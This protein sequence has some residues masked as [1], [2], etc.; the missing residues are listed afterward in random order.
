M[1]YEVFMSK[2][3]TL[4]GCGPV[5]KNVIDVTIELANQYNVPIILVASRRQIDKDGGYVGFNTKTF[6]SYVKEKDKGHNIILERDHG[7]PWEG[8]GEFDLLHVDA[9]EKACESYEEDIK[10]GF[11]ILHID[12]S[13][14]NRS[15]DLIYKD[16]IYLYDQ[17]NILALY[18]N[19][20]ISF[21][22]G[23]EECSGRLSDIKDFEYFCKNVSKLENIKYV[24]GN[25]GTL[26]KEM[27][28]YGKFNR[29]GTKQL[30]EICNKYE[31]KLKEHNLDYSPKPILNLHSK[32]GIHSSNVAPEFAIHETT[33]L[34]NCLLLNKMFKEYNKFV[35]IA[36]SSKKWEKWIKNKND[37]C[38]PKDYLAQICGHYV[39]N[40]P[41]VLEIKYIAQERFDLDYE[42]KSAIK[43]CILKYLKAFNWVK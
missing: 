28:N 29:E 30:V 18:Y 3:K 10:S 9:I 25:T 20:K 41:E 16:L 2:F 34:M 33:Q 6:A 35:D 22:V 24:V 38:Y 32:L 39:F 14:K 19:K 8:E 37:N 7:G 26:V 43:S 1:T 4:L 5:S 36:W 21:E 17:C 13:L 27:M 15:L 42:L 11:N 40:Y 23:A 12:P 31:L